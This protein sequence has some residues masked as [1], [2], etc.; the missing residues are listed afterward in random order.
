MSFVRIR[1]QITNRLFPNAGNNR[2]LVTRRPG[3]VWTPARLFDQGQM[4]IWLDPSDLGSLFQD[5]V[6][7]IPVTAPGQPVGLIRD[8]SGNGRNFTAGGAAR[9]TLGLESGKYYLDFAGAQGM[10]GLQMD[11][12]A[13]DQVLACC[14]IRIINNATQAFIYEFSANLSLNNGAFNLQAPNAAAGTNSTFASKGTAAATAVG[15][16]GAPPQTKVLTGIGEIVSPSAILRVNAAQV[17]NVVTS[18]GTGNYGD[19]SH[20]LGARGAVSNFFVGRV[21]QVIVRGGPTTAAELA[22]TEKFVNGKT[23]A[24]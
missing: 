20:Y 16:I 2:L 13:V 11:L 21:Y 23:G 9:P 3:I 4:G 24:Y 1:Q 17:A 18:Q 8:K 10:T 19:F 22:E 7:T 6:A 14:G 15:A 5:S 12:S